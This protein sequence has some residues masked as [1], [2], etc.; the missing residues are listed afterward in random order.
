MPHLAE[1]RR[2]FTVH[3]LRNMFFD[4][5]QIR[6]LRTENRQL[7]QDLEEERA[8][9]RRQCHHAAGMGLALLPYPGP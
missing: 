5:Q 2:G 6:A 4:C 3:E 7:L 1:W 9:Y 8:F